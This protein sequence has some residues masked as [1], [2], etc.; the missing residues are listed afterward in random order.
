MLASSK[1]LPHVPSH[2]VFLW[3]VL[4]TIRD[5][6]V[7]IKSLHPI[8]HYLYSIKTVKSTAEKTAITWNSIFGNKVLKPLHI[9]YF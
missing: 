8:N 7:F 2:K 9:S 5:W 3:R 6:I 4:E 1:I